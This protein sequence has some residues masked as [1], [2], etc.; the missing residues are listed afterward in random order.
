M[1]I[2]EG[3]YARIHDSYPVKCDNVSLP[4][5]Q[6]LNALLYV[7]EHGCKWR[8][9]PKQFGNWHTVYTRMNS[10]SKGY[11][12][13]SRFESSMSSSSAWLY[14]RSTQIELTRP[15]GLS[16]RDRYYE[17]GGSGTGRAGSVRRIREPALPYGP[18]GYRG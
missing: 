7:A 4:N 18:T 10:W 14:R 13:I 12:R 5:L 1:E 3:Q 11:R 17:C 8:G 9:L 15:R 2:A 16:Q 6:L